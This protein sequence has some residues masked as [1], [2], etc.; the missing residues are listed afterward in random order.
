[1]QDCC[2]KQ[3]LAEGVVLVEVGEF[4]GGCFV[5]IDM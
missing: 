4:I 3:F 5:E 1:M 2:I